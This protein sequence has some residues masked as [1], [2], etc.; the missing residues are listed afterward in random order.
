MIKVPRCNVKIQRKNNVK[1][2]DD[3][4]ENKDEGKEVKVVDE[5]VNKIMMRSM[6]KKKQKNRKE[7]VWLYF[8]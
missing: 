7:K 1:E 2:M 5:P 6:V 3:T 4:A 8:G